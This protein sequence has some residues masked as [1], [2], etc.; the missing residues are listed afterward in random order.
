MGTLDPITPVVL[1][2]GVCN[3][4][5]SSV[6][7]IIRRDPRARFKFAPLQS[8]FG[9]EQLKRFRLPTSELNSVLLLVDGKLY[10]KSSAAIKIAG[11]LNAGWPMLTIF[12]VVPVRVRDGIY[13]WVAQN[14]YR[15]FGKREVC[16][17][18]TPE[19]KSRFIG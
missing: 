15:W 13:D 4:C 6:L 14:R 1:F 12:R 2:D 7:F 10:Q 9:Q 18:P 5:N 8:E 19:L 17:I 16:M 11:R 3:L